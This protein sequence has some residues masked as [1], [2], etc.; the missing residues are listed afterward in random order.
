MR[1]KSI[2]SLLAFMVG[3][4]LPDLCWAAPQRIVSLTP[5]NTE[6]LF[7]IGLGPRVVGDTTYCDYPPA[8]RKLPK[9][10]DYQT[11]IEKVIAL[12]PD[13]VV[14]DSLLNHTAIAQLKRLH[15]PLYTFHADSL[16]QLYA[17]ITGLGR[18]TGRVAAAQSLVHRMKADMARIAAI[19]GKEHFRPKVLYIV[20]INPLWVAGPDTI[21][22][23]LIGLAGGINVAANSS[24]GYHPYSPEL[25]VADNPDVIIVSNRDVGQVQ[26]PGWEGIRAIK[27]H[28]VC[29]I[30]SDIISRTGPRLVIAL[31]QLARLLHPNA[32]K[33]QR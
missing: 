30:N 21:T 5:S 1:N 7:A 3:V 26:R 2:F 25:V 13:L 18:V 15:I 17:G 14:A 9:V 31:R 32:F 4:L 33:K 20:Q 19:V 10:G 11:S 27:D 16:S 23:E 12:R 24:P 6:I 29:G 28:A 22:N 8:A